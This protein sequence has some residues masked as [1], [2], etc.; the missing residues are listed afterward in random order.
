M[1]ENWESGSVTLQKK[2]FENI[3]FRWQYSKKKKKKIFPPRFLLQMWE[4]F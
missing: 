1:N 3:E 2:I 4:M